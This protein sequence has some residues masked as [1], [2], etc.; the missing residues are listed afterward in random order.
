MV[1]QKLWKKDEKQIERNLTF[2]ESKYFDFKRAK[3]HFNLCGH[4]H[5]ERHEDDGENLL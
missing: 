3:P 4:G 5:H 2:L 1:I